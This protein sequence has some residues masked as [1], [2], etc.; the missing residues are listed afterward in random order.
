MSIATAA[1]LTQDFVD[2][3]SAELLYAPD[4]Q[5]VFASLADAARAAALEIPD[6]MGRRGVGGFDEAMNNNMGSVNR[7]TE[8]G[9]GFCKVVQEASQPGKNVLIDRPVYLAGGFAETAY[10]LTDGTPIDTSNLN[11]PTMS[12]VS[13]MLRE[14]AGPL[15]SDG[16][17]FAPIAISEFAK[18]RAKHDLVQYMGDLL[19]RDRNCFIDSLILAL[20][21]STSH[22]TTPAGLATASM[23]AGGSPLT[24]ATLAQVKL[25]LLNRKIRPFPNGNYMLVLDPQHEKDLRGDA[26]FREITRYMGVNDH[27]PLL[28]GYLTTFGGFDIALSTNIP[29][30]AVGSGGAVA[31]YQGVAFGPESIGWAIGDDCQARRSKADDFGRQ[32]LVIWRAIEGWSLLNDAIVER[33]VTS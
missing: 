12:Q 3:L 20:L 32:D 4:S 31:G 27:G 22:T 28:S 7:L 9:R 14:Y 26:A 2:M 33:I 29:H 25:N 15:K 18:N 21:L 1:S 24:E 13:V 11:A 10:R 16:S 30:A 8:A 5:W 23:T 6:L 19:R 17:A